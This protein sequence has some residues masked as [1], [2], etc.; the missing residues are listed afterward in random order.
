[1]V[2]LKNL[3]N[4]LKMVRRDWLPKFPGFLEDPTYLEVS[5]VSGNNPWPPSMQASIDLASK[6]TFVGHEIFLCKNPSSMLICTV[7]SLRR[8]A[9]E[10]FMTEK[11]KARILA[12]LYEA[13]GD[14]DCSPLKVYA[15]TLKYFAAAFSGATTAEQVRRNWD[16][17]F[18]TLNNLGKPSPGEDAYFKTK[19]VSK[20]G[21]NTKAQPR[22][23]TPCGRFN[24]AEG[25]NTQPACEQRYRP[26]LCSECLKGSKGQRLRE[27]SAAGG[28][29]PLRRRD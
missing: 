14:P 16:S 26:H 23:I 21:A 15:Q 24:S 2:K 1:M 7:S 22:Q 18:F 8:L 20:A 5:L 28:N 6:S 3:P 9:A 25:C 12:N 17:N 29:C 13:W 11:M 4:E 10:G 19:S 27:H